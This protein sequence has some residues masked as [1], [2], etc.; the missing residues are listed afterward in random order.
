[1]PCIRHDDPSVPARLPLAPWAEVDVDQPGRHDEWRCPSQNE[2]C[3]GRPVKAYTVTHIVLPTVPRRSMMPL[4]PLA[5]HHL[6]DLAGIADRPRWRCDNLV[7]APAR[8]TVQVVCLIW[9]HAPT[10]ITRLAFPHYALPDPIVRQ[11]L[12]RLRL[13]TWEI[14]I[15]RWCLSV[16]R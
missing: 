12:Q 8:T 14:R 4:T 15:E 6:G 1:M 5:H 10:A 11:M 7:P 2:T 9:A 13:Y 16:E 3:T